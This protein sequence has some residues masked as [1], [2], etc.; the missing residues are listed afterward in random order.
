M[1]GQK[2]IKNN[3]SKLS[4]HPLTFEEAVRDIL[5]VGRRKTGNEQKGNIRYGKYDSKRKTED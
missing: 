4:L 1:G 2:S 3:N 5:Q